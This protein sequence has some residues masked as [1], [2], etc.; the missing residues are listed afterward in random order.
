MRRLT[1]FAVLIVL[2]SCEPGDLVNL[3]SAPSR[4]TVVA[5]NVVGQPWV[6][7]V[8]PSRPNDLALQ[9]RYIPRGIPDATVNIYEDG[10]FVEQLQL[11]T[12]DSA[13]VGSIFD[14]F[15]SMFRSNTN[16][17][18]PGHEYKITVES[19][20]YPPATAT[21]TQPQ[22]VPADISFEFREMKPYV[23]QVGVSDGTTTTIF[24]DTAKLWTFD[25]AITF[26]DP[27]GNNYY[28]FWLT[29]SSTRSGLDSTGGYYLIEEGPY[30]DPILEGGSLKDDKTF[31]GQRVT[32]KFVY[33]FQ[34]DSTQ[35]YVSKL[36]NW[37]RVS[38]RSLSE[39]QYK[40]II[41][42]RQSETLDF[43]PYAQPITTFTNV[44]SGLG[45]FGGYTP[46]SKDFYFKSK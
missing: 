37:F 20:D 3:P 10:N 29:T 1:F 41:Q 38:L 17:P 46:S 18:K 14:E 9:H 33:T 23:F 16:S 36:P 45:I 15:A 39:G 11:V 26:T 34:E 5:S 43:D 35:Y 7:F 19:K 22:P 40:S 30:K 2:G 42:T 12:Y 28:D 44:E 8:A 31:A 21:Y 24:Y 32:F 4:I 6:I 25:V 13:V 27:P